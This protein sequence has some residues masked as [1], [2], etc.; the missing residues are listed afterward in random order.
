MTSSI[1]R[2]W[3]RAAAVAVLSGAVVG[4]W[5]VG[6]ARFALAEPIKPPLEVS[7]REEPA[8]WNRSS[9]PAPAAR[10]DPA[11]KPA[12]AVVPPIP[13]LPKVPG[14]PRPLPPAVAPSGPE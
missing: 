11:V 9:A 10:P 12:S 7:K 3:R 1:R 8:V 6:F 5:W 4:G 14:G 13:A 2:R